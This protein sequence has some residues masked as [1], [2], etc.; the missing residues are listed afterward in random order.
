MM[1]AKIGG[2]HP[3]SP[4]PPKIP[5]PPSV[6]DSQIFPNLFQQAQPEST[7]IMKLK[8]SIC[9]SLRLTGGCSLNHLYLTLTRRHRVTVSIGAICINCYAEN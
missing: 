7:Y 3:P 4:Y 1:S 6:S 5:L 2:R 8:S 9:S